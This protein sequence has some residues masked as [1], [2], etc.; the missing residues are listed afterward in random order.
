MVITTSTD[1]EMKKLREAIQE[2][3]RVVAEQTVST[4]I[5]EHSIGEF[6][7]IME[8]AIVGLGEVM[9]ELKDLANTVP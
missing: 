7:T 6:Q 1:S 5:L 2:L 9:E 4:E 8:E 3:T